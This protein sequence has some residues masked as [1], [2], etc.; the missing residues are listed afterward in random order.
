MQMLGRIGLLAS[1]A[2]WDRGLRSLSLASC[3]PCL[4]AFLEDSVHPDLR[5][6][7][8]DAQ[9]VGSL[10]DLPWSASSAWSLKSKSR[11]A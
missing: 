2:C 8:I 3:L 5:R 11:R 1:S 4:C 7:V 10:R 6:H 9:L